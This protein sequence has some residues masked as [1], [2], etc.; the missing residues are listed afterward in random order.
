MVWSPYCWV[1]SKHGEKI[2]TKNMKDILSRLVKSL[3]SAYSLTKKSMSSETKKIGTGLLTVESLADTRWRKA[4]SEKS[5]NS[6][7]A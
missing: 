1:I 3:G 7:K 4:A 2:C 5:L 6:Q